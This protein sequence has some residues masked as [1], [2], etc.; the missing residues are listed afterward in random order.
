MK[1]DPS[2]THRRACPTLAQLRSI[3]S[4]PTLPLDDAVVDHL[5][6]CTSCQDMVEQLARDDNLRDRLDERSGSQVKTRRSTA[7]WNAAASRLAGRIAAAARGEASVAATDSNLVSLPQP[8]LPR[9]DGY[10]ILGLLGRGGMGAVYHAIHRKFNRPVAIK[11]LPDA[12]NADPARLQRFVREMAAIGQLDHP[13]IVQAYDAADHHSTHYIV[14]ELVR[15]RTVSDIVRHH[16]RLTIEDSCEIVRQTAIA[17][18]HAHDNGLVHRDIKP[19]NMMVTRDGVVKL[20]DLGLARLSDGGE[21]IASELTTNGQIIGTLDYMSPEQAAG[22]DQIGAASDIYSLGATLY[23]MI[24]GHPVFA[25][26]SHASVLS[27][28][29][30]LERDPPQSLRSFRDDVPE[31]LD[32]LVMRMLNKSPEQRNIV[33][34]QIADTIGVYAAGADLTALAQTSENNVPCPGD[35]TEDTDC[36]LNAMSTLSANSEALLSDQTD[37]SSEGVS[38][39]S[40]RKS[41]LRPLLIVGAIGVALAIASPFTGAFSSKSSDVSSPGNDRSSFAPIIQ[42]SPSVTPRTHAAPTPQTEPTSTTTLTN[43]ADPVEQQNEARQSRERWAKDHGME[44]TMVVDLPKG[45]QLKLMLIPPGEFLMGSDLTEIASLWDSRNWFYVRRFVETQSPRHLVHITQPF[46]IGQCEVTRGQFREFVEAT[47]FETEAERTGRAKGFV[48]GIMVPDKRFVWHSSFEFE[49]QDDHP[50][51][52]VTRNDAF[53]FC[54][55]LDELHPGQKFDLP[56]EAQ[57][58]YAARAGSRSHWYFGN[59]P[60]ELKKHGWYNDNSPDLTNPVAQLLPNAWGLYDV[61]GNVWEFCRDRFGAD[62]YQQSPLEDPLG[63]T[64]GELFVMRSGCWNNPTPARTASPSRKGTA[65]EE[66]SVYVGFRVVCPVG[67]MN[68]P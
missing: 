36:Y 66:A 8:S 49:Q 1:D 48:K 28:L 44:L 12:S 7:A 40:S 33:A 6:Q 22:S 57:W 23:R 53:A 25:G 62:Y 30:A 5:E 18:Q 19:S 16:G 58:E 63:P 42:S 41:V 50:V 45:N 15:G 51:V 64:E 52:N 3:A 2:P 38:D 32:W 34:S 47:G 31:E 29:N 43:V 26:P 4:D 9:I 20:L 68:S 21:F 56:T 55:W 54:R 59:E 14:M 24:A 27:K 60:N 61:Y 13:G 65:P 35:M 67:T 17:L 10:E 39:E 46:W 11:I 37:A